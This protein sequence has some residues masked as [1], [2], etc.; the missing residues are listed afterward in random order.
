MESDALK[1]WV[2]TDGRAGNEA[3]ALGLAEALARRRP[4]KITTR[5]IPPKDWTARMPAHLWHGLGA[6]EGGWPF[7]AY[8][9]K[10]RRIKPP[11]PDL[12][13]GAGRRIA[14]LVAALKQ[15]Y[16]VRTVQILDPQMPL[17]DFDLV[18][19]PDHDR[20]TNGNVITTLGAVGRNTPGIVAAA[21]EPWRARLRNLPEPRVAVLLGGP[22]KLA[23][24]GGGAAGRVTD[25]LEAL[26]EAGYGLMVT[27]SLRTPEG[28]VSRLREALGEDAF[29]WDGTGDNPYPGILELAEAVLVTSDSVN[30]ASEAASTGKP[31]YVFPLKGMAGKI[32]RFHAALEA[33]GAAR[34]FEGAIES[35]SYPP[36]AEADRVAAEVEARLIAEGVSPQTSG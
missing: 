2:L 35:W 4:C 20:V 34:R 16:G 21:A 14:P 23:R 18:V 10:V 30:M 29:V 36:L 6:R 22:S 5:R 28:L 9:P 25:A 13:I 26:A 31:V 17:T 19:I 33:H 1:I 8:K 11:W 7:N 3:Q 27:P 32:T 15:L 12:A 24:F